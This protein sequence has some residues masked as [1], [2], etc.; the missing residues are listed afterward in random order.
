MATRTGASDHVMGRGLARA[1]ETNGPHER[2]NLNRS[3]CR[4][5]LAIRRFDGKVTERGIPRNILLVNFALQGLDPAGYGQHC[6]QLAP[7]FADLPGLVSKTWLADPETNTFGG[8]YVWRDR[9]ALENY[10]ASDIFTSLGANPHLT[11]VSARE[12]GVLE[13]P[14]RITRGAADAAPR[15]QPQPYIGAESR[16]PLG[17]FPGRP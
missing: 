2:H 7:L 17:G 11:N 1:A 15:P 13:R 3:C 10:L 8:L 5:C 16:W 12:F 6:E 4:V 9:E 14:T